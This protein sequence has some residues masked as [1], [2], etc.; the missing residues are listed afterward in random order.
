MLFRYQTDTDLLNAPVVS[1]DVN[2]HYSMQITLSDDLAP[3][4]YG[5]LVWSPPFEEEAKRRAIVDVVAP[6]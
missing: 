5:V 6:A 3:G 4:R 1:A 2:G